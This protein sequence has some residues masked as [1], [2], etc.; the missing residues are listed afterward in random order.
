MSE[1][2]L[3]VRSSP[4][5]RY[6]RR[7]WFWLGVAIPS[8]LAGTSWLLT[9][10][11]EPAGS[12]EPHVVPPPEAAKVEAAEEE[13]AALDWPTDRLEGEPAKELLL[14]VLLAAQERLSAVE[15]YTCTLHRQE[16]IKGKL[17]EPQTI[18][19]K[20]RHR[21]FGVYLRF[22]SPEEGREVIYSEGR[23][24]NDMIAH[25]GGLTRA[26][27]PRLKV[28]P[29]STLALAGNRHPITDAGLLQLTEKLVGFRRM[30][31]EDVEAITVLDRVTDD[32]GQT[33]L[34][35]IHDHPHYHAERPFKYVEVLYDPQT[36]LP[37]RISSY[38]WPKP[39]Q[40]G[41]LELAE[42]YFYDDLELD[43][44]LSDLDFDPANPAYEFKR[45]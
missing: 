43:A 31:L 7:P 38:D 14:R 28:S 30:D 34:R 36:K 23:Y 17:G 19:M 21:P 35:S 4:T 13:I 15:G 5:P 20:V 42:R 37:V 10:D 16:R 8:L 9:A 29:D 41:E 44:P 25:P 33:W 2:A 24:D 39:G 45:F 12:S 3:L 27:L 18:T 32:E 1:K 22:Q 11:L 6:Y 40:T 26:F